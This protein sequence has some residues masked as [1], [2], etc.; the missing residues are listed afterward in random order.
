VSVLVVSNDFAY[1]LPAKPGI[2]SRTDISV[3]LIVRAVALLS[4][5]HSLDKHC[6]MIVTFSTV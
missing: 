3:P 6:H 4:D 1:I 2:A 5:L